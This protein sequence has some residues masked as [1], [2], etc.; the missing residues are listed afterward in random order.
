MCLPITQPSP[1]RISSVDDMAR[2]VTAVGV[3]RVCADSS[4]PTGLALQP[5]CTR[6]P[7]VG[8]GLPCWTAG[9]RLSRLVLCSRR[10]QICGPGAH[11]AGYHHL[12]FRVA[13]TTSSFLCKLSGIMLVVSL[14]LYLMFITGK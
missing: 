10:V 12:R 7:R 5:A 9:F 8:R 4:E 6:W 1:Y 3:S 2:C 11:L 14:F 13:V